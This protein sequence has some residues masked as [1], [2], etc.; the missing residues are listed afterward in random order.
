[1]TPSIE[2]GLKL[3]DA[4]PESS[5]TPPFAKNR[6]GSPLP[7]SVGSKLAI[8]ES[9][10]L[11]GFERQSSEEGVPTEPHRRASGGV[12]EGH[13]VGGKEVGLHPG[14]TSTPRVS[15]T[16]RPLAKLHLS[17]FGKKMLRHR[18]GSA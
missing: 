2:D 16:A 15:S 18:C 11:P 14:R 12:P 17:T 9:V 13:F 8:T 10:A 6:E 4:S 3:P 5:F 7:G 1:M